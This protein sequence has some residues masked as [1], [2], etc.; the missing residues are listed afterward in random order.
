MPAR[1]VTFEIAGKPF[2]MA[3]GE[4]LHI[5]NS[6]KYGLR[7]ARLMLRAGGWSPVAD[8]SDEQDWFTLILAEARAFRHAPLTD[9][10]MIGRLASVVSGASAVSARHVRIQL[11]E[12]RQTGMSAASVIRKASPSHT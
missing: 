7:D 2:S 9:Q 8:W 11:C 1:D 6:H 3:Q 10:C 12:P 5:E 4:R